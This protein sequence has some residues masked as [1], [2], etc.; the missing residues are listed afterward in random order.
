[1]E[2][3]QI[4]AFSAQLRSQLRV[5][6]QR[7]CGVAEVEWGQAG[8]ANERLSDELICLTAPP[9]IEPGGFSDKLILCHL[10]TTLWSMFH[11]LQRSVVTV[12]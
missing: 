4:T 6:L 10:S 8:R 5:C 3:H 2:Q 12:S 1:M 11:N 9:Y 7:S